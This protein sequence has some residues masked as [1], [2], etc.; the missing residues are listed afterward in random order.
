[1][2]IIPAVDIKD[3]KCVQLVQGKP[4]TEQVI[5]ENPAEVAKEW[6]K[7]GASI[8][9]IINLDG[10]FGD[11]EKNVDVIKEIIN[12]VSIPV[13][14]GGGIRTKEDAAEL[15]KMGVD[16]VILGTMAIENPEN[17]AELSGEFG[18]ERII[19]AL[20]SKDS[21]V[22]VKGWT[23][24][25]EKS[26]PE[27]GKIFEKKGAGGILFTN[28]DYEGLLNGFDTAPLIELLDEVNIPIIYSGG[29][30]SIDDI[31]KLSLT[32]VYGAVIGSALYKGKIDFEE[33]LLTSKS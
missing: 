1:M 11:K 16:K 4:G 33:A 28:V 31:K 5:I 22:V 3:G 30:T 8:L 12:A 14:L 2:L 10:A 15:L 21:K 18:S 9:H 24:K 23:E 27:F 29:V 32:D 17:V 19:I 20:D 6:E 26:A 7:K 25:T 13:Q